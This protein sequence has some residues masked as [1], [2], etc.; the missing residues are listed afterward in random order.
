MRFHVRLKIR[1]SIMMK[2]LVGESTRAAASLEPLNYH[3]R[4]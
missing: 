2:R 4:L 1:E 3:G